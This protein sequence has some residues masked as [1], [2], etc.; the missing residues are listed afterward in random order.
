MRPPHQHTV[1]FSLVL[2]LLCS[3]TALA[4]DPILF[5]QKA[6]DRGEFWFF[7]VTGYSSPDG[8]TGLFLTEQTMQEGYQLALQPGEASLIVAKT[9]A[10]LP[11]PA[12]ITL[13]YA[14]LQGQATV[15]VAAPQ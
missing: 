7:P 3:M 1:V 8:E 10:A 5:T 6:L 12:V 9:P 4:A 13:E 2:L 15:A 14:V 11:Q